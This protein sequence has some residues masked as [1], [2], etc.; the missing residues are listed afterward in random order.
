[1]STEKPAFKTERIAGWAARQYQASPPWRCR[2]VLSSRK[3]PFSIVARPCRPRSGATR[4]PARRDCP[5]WLASGHRGVAQSAPQG[6]A[7]GR[8]RERRAPL[9]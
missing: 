4:A 5:L 2:P 7:A 9:A 1:V 6:A 3:A 8:H